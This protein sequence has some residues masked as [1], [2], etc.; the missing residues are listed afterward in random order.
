MFSNA[1]ICDFDLNP[2]T[3][4]EPRLIE[5]IKK[6][7]YRENRINDDLVEKDFNIDKKD[8]AKIKKYFEGKKMKKNFRHADMVE[9]DKNDFASR[10]TSRLNWGMSS[11]AFSAKC[12]RCPPPLGSASR[13]KTVFRQRLPQRSASPRLR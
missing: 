3:E 12:L 7:Y 2:I 1:E 6:K 13:A 5:Y 8:I 4:L 10:H 11:C 9:R